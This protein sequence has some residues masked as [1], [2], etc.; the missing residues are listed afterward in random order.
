M[1]RVK[2]SVSVGAVG[3]D[4]IPSQNDAELEK[5]TYYNGSEFSHSGRAIAKRARLWYKFIKKQIVSFLPQEIVDI[6]SE[7][8]DIVLSYDDDND[9][10]DRGRGSHHCTSDE[11]LAY[12]DVVA[13]RL[14]HDIEW[15]KHHSILISGSGGPTARV[16]GLGLGSRVCL[17]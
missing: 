13:P 5:L 12:V 15:F 6:P 9:E 2:D 1:N 11:F 7:I 16:S 10:K 17:A 4:Y 14:N 8:A 3:G